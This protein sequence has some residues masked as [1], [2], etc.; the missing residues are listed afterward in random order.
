MADLPLTNIPPTANEARRWLENGAHKPS[1]YLKLFWPAFPW[2]NCKNDCREDCKASPQCLMGC[3]LSKSRKLYL[4]RALAQIV[5]QRERSRKRRFYIRQNFDRYAGG[6]DTWHPCFICGG[7]F[8]HRHH[9][10]QIQHGGGNRWLN[11]VRLC[12]SCH[13]AVHNP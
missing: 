2:K 5:L 8:H 11:I 13:R 7:Q 3:N 4:I 12:R 9:L 6:R 1:R 10:I